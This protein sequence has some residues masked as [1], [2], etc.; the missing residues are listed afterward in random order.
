MSHKQ[1]QT[2]RRI[3]FGF[4]VSVLLLLVLALLGGG[5]PRVA[6]LQCRRHNQ[7][8]RPDN[9]QLFSLRDGPRARRSGGI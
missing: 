6:G 4:G 2:T 1:N 8:D 7:H 9:A 5:R 3:R